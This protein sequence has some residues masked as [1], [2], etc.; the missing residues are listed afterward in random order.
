MLCPLCQEGFKSKDSLEEH[1]MQLHSIN[2]EGLQR[3]MMLMQG[4]HWLNT[5]KKS[6][7]DEGEKDGGGKLSDIKHQSMDL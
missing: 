4:S 1:A 5:M 2:A 3:L 7:K 6:D